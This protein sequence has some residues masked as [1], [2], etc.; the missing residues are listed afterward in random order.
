MGTK[1]L[2]HFSIKKL[3]QLNF[4]MISVVIGDLRMFYQ[5]SAT[6]VKSYA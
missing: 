5:G 6:M 1:I 2:P 3:N 4:S